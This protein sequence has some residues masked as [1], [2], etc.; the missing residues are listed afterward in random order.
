MGRLRWSPQ[1]FRPRSPGQI[2]ASGKLHTGGRI[3]QPGSRKPLL[4]PGWPVC[5]PLLAV[6]TPKHP[7]PSVAQPWAR[8]P[9]RVAPV[10]T[11]GSLCSSGSQ[12]AG[13]EAQPPSAP[14]PAN[15]SQAKTR[16]RPRRPCDPGARPT[17][18]PPLQPGSR[19]RCRWRRG[20]GGGQGGR[21]GRAAAEAPGALP[22]RTPR[23]MGGLAGG[24]GGRAAGDFQ[25]LQARAAAGVAEPK[26]PER[27]EQG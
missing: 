6:V 11:W 20:R 9:S 13:L 16:P 24:G 8:D 7:D 4:R 27:R 2:T 21:G 19:T 25:E 12:R 17:P 23:S 15:G 26:G 5:V 22:P 18:Q 14:R 10:S 1:A 3:S